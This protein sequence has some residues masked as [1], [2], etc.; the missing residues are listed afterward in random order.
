MAAW[1]HC[2]A[3]SPFLL[4]CVLFINI[5]LPSEYGVLYKYS[6]VL[7]HSNSSVFSWKEY[8]AELSA[9]FLLVPH[10]FETSSNTLREELE[11]FKWALTHFLPLT[12]MTTHWGK[13]SCTPY[14]ILPIPLGQN[15]LYHLTLEIFYLIVLWEFFSPIVK[16]KSLYSYPT[17][18]LLF[19]CSITWFS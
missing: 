18:Y 12:N 11:S 9:K 17:H 10:C 7:E 6:F 1:S 14:C 19:H 13:N 8:S 15:I 4:V 3:Y 16:Y 5:Q 2:V